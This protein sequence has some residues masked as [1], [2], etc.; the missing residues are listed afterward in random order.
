MRGKRVLLACRLQGPETKKSRRRDQPE[1]AVRKEAKAYDA[2]RAADV[3]TRLPFG[4]L[5]DS[6]CA[7]KCELESHAA[8][9]LRST[10]HST[11]HSTAFRRHRLRGRENAALHVDRP[12]EHAQPRQ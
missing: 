2:G 4:S 6:E 8:T 7:V 10:S 1:H 9:A 12:H 11:S 5:C 3:G